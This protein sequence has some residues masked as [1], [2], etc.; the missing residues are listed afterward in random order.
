[1]KLTLDKVAIMHPN[2][3]ISDISF[4]VEDGKFFG[5]IGESGCGKTTIAKAILRILPESAKLTSG[6]ILINGKDIS[7]MGRDVVNQKIG[8]ISQNF[9]G[10]LCDNITIEKHLR[11]KLKSLGINDVIEQNKQIHQ[12]LVMVG[13]PDDQSVNE[14]SILQFIK[15]Y[16]A[17]NQIS[18]G[19]KQKMCIAISLLGNPELL[20]ADEAT[21]AL[22]ASVKLSFMQRLID[23]QKQTGITI[24]FIT[25][26]LLLINRFADS[27]AIIC[28]SEDHECKRKN[29]GQIVEHCKSKPFMLYHPYS[30]A[31]KNAIPRKQKV[32]YKENA[33]PLC[34]EMSENSCLYAEQCIQRDSLCLE[35]SPPKQD[36]NNNTVWCHYP[37]E[38]SF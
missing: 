24:M 30:V 4:T 9:A 7:L 17:F 34:G 26:D 11:Y 18:G 32:L 21:S 29:H 28:K 19:Q 14:K 38:E 12:I 25:H 33:I 27:I 5:L 2:F 22:D 36:I 3:S 23:I 16:P 10:S 20:I 35:E 37:V 6:R 13:L 15:K 31:L 8:Y 1:M